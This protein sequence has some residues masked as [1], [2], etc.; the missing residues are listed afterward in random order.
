MC[1]RNNQAIEVKNVVI[2][3]RVK[4][5]GKNWNGKPLR[6]TILRKLFM[7]LWKMGVPLENVLVHCFD[8]EVPCSLKAM[9]D[10][11]LLK[12]QSRKPLFKM[13]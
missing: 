3:T 8:D 7:L 1:Y 10:G 2:I 4:F 6:N 5:Q 11:W 9:F 12:L 13:K